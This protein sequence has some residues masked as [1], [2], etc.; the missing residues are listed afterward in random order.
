MGI[1]KKERDLLASGKRS[2]KIEVPY[3]LIESGKKGEKKPLI[4]YLH[5][6]GENIK[7]FQNKCSRFLDINAYHLFIQ[8]PYPIY[9]PSRKK[10][11]SNWGRSWYLYDGNRKQFIKSL[12]ITSEFIQEVIDNLIKFINVSKIC[13]LGYSMGGYQAGF[14]SLT[15]WKHVNDVIV[16]GARIKT[17]V[18]KESDYK[19]LNHMNILAVHGKNDEKVRFEGQKVSIEQLKSKGLQ[20]ELVLL[21]ENHDFS[22]QVIEEIL[23]WFQSNGYKFT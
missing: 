1:K 7:T 11:V 13:V 5:G 20:G 23:R 8:G 6:Y 9:D 4:L 17:E 15:R 3:Q 22:I 21:D 18:L 19:N 12:E 2:F 10:T 16:V 14:F